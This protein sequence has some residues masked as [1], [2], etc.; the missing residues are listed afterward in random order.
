ME[1]FLSRK[2]C[3]PIKNPQ[4]TSTW[5]WD[6]E[7]FSSGDHLCQFKNMV[8]SHKY[9]WCLLLSTSSI[10]LLQHNYCFY[11]QSSKTKMKN[12]TRLTLMTTYLW[13]PDQRL[14]WWSQERDSVW[15][16]PKSPQLRHSALSSSGKVWVRTMI[17]PWCK[18][19]N[20][21]SPISVLPENDCQ[22]C[23]WY[24]KLRYWAMIWL[25]VLMKCSLAEQ[26]G[27]ILHYCL[28]LDG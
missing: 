23:K 26:F 10:C 7:Y 25:D 11:N 22:Y 20:I 13:S 6:V 3:Y 18:R 2:A 1:S 19:H 15:S 21:A 14:R 27:W 5:E 16:S 28:C 12:R 17:R 8:I 9:F 4:S 24:L